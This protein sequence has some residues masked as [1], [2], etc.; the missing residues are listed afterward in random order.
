MGAPRRISTAQRIHES[1]FAL[2]GVSISHATGISPGDQEFPFF[3]RMRD[4]ISLYV[5]KATLPGAYSW[6]DHEPL[7]DL[8]ENDPFMY[9]DYMISGIEYAT[10]QGDLKRLDD[11][12]KMATS[13]YPSKTSST[14]RFIYGSIISQ[15][16]PKTP[17][18]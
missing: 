1:V 16:S 3:R 8:V 10:K 5:P 11:V 12:V 13:I 17:C 6:K 7:A 14:A 4:Y 2:M 18:H 9:L 15:I